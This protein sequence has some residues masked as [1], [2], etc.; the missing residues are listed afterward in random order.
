MLGGV[1]AAQLAASQGVGFVQPGWVLT[2]P[3]AADALTADRTNRV[4]RGI[5]FSGQLG[6]AINEI[7]LKGTLSP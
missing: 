4:L 6:G 3:K 7:P 5:E 2:T 1:V